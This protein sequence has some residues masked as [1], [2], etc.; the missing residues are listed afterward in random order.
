M[1][2]EQ[3]WLR[4]HAV[5]GYKDNQAFRSIYYNCED[6][7]VATA[8]DELRS[9]IAAMTGIAARAYRQSIPSERAH[10]QLRVNK[11]K[12]CFKSYGQ[13]GYEI[14]LEGD[15]III[16]AYAGVG[17][18]YGSFALL[19]GIGTQKPID[20]IC[21]FSRPDNPL[22]MLNHWD[23]IDGSIE[24]GYAGESFFFRNA[25]ILVDER[26]KD[27]ARLASS[28]GINSVVINNVNVANEAVFSHYFTL[29]QATGK[30]F[31]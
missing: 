12:A 15:S 22:R 17:I 24:R 21:G 10:I 30:G 8:V 1:E 19:R 5:D 4:Y 13:E 28:V 6:V 23:N 7:C 20:E 29:L 11:E 9:G 3:C 2:W 18:L 16:S 27:Y 25:E 26:T 14:F 31:F